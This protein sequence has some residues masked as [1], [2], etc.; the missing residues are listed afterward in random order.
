MHQMNWGQHK[1]RVRYV[2]TF[3]FMN[4]N[5]QT[6]ISI[7]MIETLTNYFGGKWTQLDNVE[8]SV[9]QQLTGDYATKLHKNFGV[10]RYKIYLLPNISRHLDCPRLRFMLNAWL[11]AR[12]KCTYYYYYYNPRTSQNISCC[13]V[14][15][16][17]ICITQSSLL[18]LSLFSVFC[19]SVLNPDSLVITL[20]CK[21]QLIFIIIIIHEFHGDTSLK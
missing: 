4:L 18:S 19:Y 14:R 6:F 21:R 20:S 2:T 12:Y 11:C 13:G 17:S 8:L 5:C 7:N 3:P 9:N 15:W 1:T 16:W 10:V